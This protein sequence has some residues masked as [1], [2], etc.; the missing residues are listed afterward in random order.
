MVRGCSFTSMPP[1]LPPLQV[2]ML[3]GHM[4][5]VM[6]V[7]FSPSAECLASASDDRTVRLW[8]NISGQQ[9]ASLAGRGDGR[10]KP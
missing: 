2:A 4:I 5:G 10:Q 1:P 9:L 7:A 6:A 8:N 3:E